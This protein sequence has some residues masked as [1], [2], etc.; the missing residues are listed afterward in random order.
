MGYHSGAWLGSPDVRADDLDG[1][2]DRRLGE[3]VLGHAV[4]IVAARILHALHGIAVEGLHD[5]RVVLAPL[6]AFRAGMWI[7]KPAQR[8]DRTP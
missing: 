8:V 5:P 3:D 1:A 2:P 7:S 6:D 4:I